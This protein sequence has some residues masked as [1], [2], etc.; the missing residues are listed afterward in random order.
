MNLSLSANTQNNALSQLG[1]GG[2]AEQGTE[3]EHS[4]DQNGQ[5]VSGDTSILSGNS[6]LCQTMEN[7]C[8]SAIS[9]PSI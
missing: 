3:Q 4:S 5:V 9:R 7:S 1:N 8:E 6:I 2:T